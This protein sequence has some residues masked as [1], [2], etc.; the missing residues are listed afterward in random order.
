MQFQVGAGGS[1]PTFFELIAADRLVPSLRAALVYSL[2]VHAARRPGL[3]FPPD[4]TLLLVAT[5]LLDGPGT[6]GGCSRLSGAEAPS[7]GHQAGEHNVLSV[8]GRTTNHAQ[9]RT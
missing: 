8:H 5:Y 4:P 2:G 3:T 7:W 6:D 1:R 9:Q